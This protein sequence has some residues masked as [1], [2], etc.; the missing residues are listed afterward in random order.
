MKKYFRRA[1]IS[2]MEK[3][4]QK[5]KE[6]QESIRM[7][8]QDIPQGLQRMHQVRL[9]GVS[10]NI[11]AGSDLFMFHALVTAHRKDQFLLRRKPAQRLLEPTLI[12]LGKKL[13]FNG[14]GVWIQPIRHLLA[15]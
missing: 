9:Y 1:G 2:P 12:F 8:M 4:L 14:A 10:R 11:Q 13:I 15:G 7:K 3:R 6:G 5:K